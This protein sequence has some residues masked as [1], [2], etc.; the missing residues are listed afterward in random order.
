MT[1]RTA[2]TLGITGHTYETWRRDTAQNMCM[3]AYLHYMLKLSER[4]VL[5]SN[6]EVKIWG[7]N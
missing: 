5:I 6:D 1:E 3:H 2:V 7:H 4:P